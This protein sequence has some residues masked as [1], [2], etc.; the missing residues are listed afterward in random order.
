DVVR[1]RILDVRIRAKG[2][3]QRLDVEAA[4]PQSMDAV[5]ADRPIDVDVGLRPELRELVGAQLAAELDED[6][7]GRGVVAVHRDD[8]EARLGTLARERRG[9]DADQSQQEKQYGGTRTEVRTSHRGTLSLKRNDCSAGGGPREITT[10]SSTNACSDGGYGNFAN[11]S[12][13]G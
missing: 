6:F 7:A 13:A 8:T 9:C 2:I 5:R 11:F 12:R 1:L 10:P 3:E 4:R